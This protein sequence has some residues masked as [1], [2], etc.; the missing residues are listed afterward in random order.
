MVLYKMQFGSTIVDPDLWT[1]QGTVVGE[2]THVAKLK[3]A[4]ST[5]IARAEDEDANSPCIVDSEAVF[6]A[7]RVARVYFEAW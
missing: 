1:G 7:A 6:W 5:P 3:L 2:H 4:R